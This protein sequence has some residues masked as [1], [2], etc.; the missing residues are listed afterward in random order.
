MNWRH[1]FKEIFSVDLRVLA[2]FRISIGLALLINLLDRAREMVHYTDEILPVSLVKQSYISQGNFSFHV[3]SGNLI[4][5]AFLFFIAM[6]LAL[7]VIFGAYTRISVFLSWVFFLSL[8]NRNPWFVFGADVLLV[9]MLFWAIFLPL[10]SKFSFDSLKKKS[11]NSKFFSWAVVGAML[12]VGLMY[13]FSA[14]WKLFSGPEW[15][16]NGNGIFLSLQTFFGLPSSDFLFMFPLVLKIFSLIIPFFEIAVIFLFFSPIYT[17]KTRIIAIV[18]FSIFHISLSLFLN[19]GVFV[20]I[21][22]ASLTL[23]LPEN[24][25]FRSKKSILLEDKGSISVFLSYFFIF[26]IFLS[27]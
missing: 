18:L 2:V 21:C 12:Q 3:F 6:I 8:M 24:L 20:F 23:F 14:I 19:L 26:I 9:M 16:P 4:F 27:F 15:F 11:K 10:G 13:F 22:I 5:Q 25:L 17:D 1:K 7:M